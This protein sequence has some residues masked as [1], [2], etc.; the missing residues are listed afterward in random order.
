MKAPLIRGMGLV[1]L[2]CAVALACTPEGAG[3]PEDSGDT[4]A[5]AP[6]LQTLDLSPAPDATPAPDAA[7]MCGQGACAANQRC[8]RDRCVPVDLAHPPAAMIPAGTFTMGSHPDEPGRAPDED[9][10]LIALDHPFLM[11]ISEVTHQQW[12]DA[13]AVRL[14]AAD[15]CGLDCPVEGVTWFEAAFLANQLSAI[16]GLPDCYTLTD[17]DEAQLGRGMT[18]AGAVPVGVDCTG[19]R[20]PTE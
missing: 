12:L 14:P 18:C 9:Q 13:L 6:D 1:G 17:C 19:Y 20:L 15:T 2:V 16:H 4:D 10:R 5:I 8:V 7:P 3:G 11:S